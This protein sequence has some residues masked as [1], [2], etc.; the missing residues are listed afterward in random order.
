MCFVKF[1]T[2]EEKH[3]GK[4]FERQIR[5][6]CLVTHILPIK[7]QSLLREVAQNISQRKWALYLLIY[8]LYNIKSHKQNEI[9]IFESY[10]ERINKKKKITIIIY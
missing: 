1:I 8:I 10:H 4:M 7:F 2:H 3:L 6:K 9:T 5:A